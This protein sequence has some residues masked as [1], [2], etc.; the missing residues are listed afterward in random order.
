MSDWEKKEN[1]NT[2]RTAILT[3]Y[4]KLFTDIPYAPQLFFHAIR[5]AVGYGFSFEPSL[6]VEKM[7]LE[8]EARHKA[9]NAALREQIDADTLVVELGAGLSPRRLEFTVKAYDDAG[10]IGEGTHERFLVNNEKFQKKADAKLE[11]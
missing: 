11:K 7:S 5:L 9:L 3:A 6:F 8:I 1:W 2:M 10:L 4:P